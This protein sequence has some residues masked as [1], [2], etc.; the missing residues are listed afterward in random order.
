MEGTIIVGEPEI[1]A[2]YDPPNPLLPGPPGDLIRIEPIGARS[3]IRAWR[4][5]YHSTTRA[6]ED[7]MVSGMIAAP[8]RDPP[9]GGFPL[10]AS[11]H[12]TTGI[13]RRCAPSIDPDVP[14]PNGVSYF[15][16]LAPYVDAG[17][18]IAA[19]D[20][21]GLGAPGDPAYLVGE[22]ES[23]NVL[24][25]ARAARAL[26]DLRT[27]DPLLI[28]GHSQGGHAAAFAG[29]IIPQ[30]APEQRVAGVV[31]LAPAAELELMAAG[32]AMVRQPIP[33]VAFLVAAMYSWSLIYADA[34]LDA[35]LTEAGLDAV[36]TLKHH[37]G[38]DMYPPFMSEPPHHYF[39]P[40][41]IVLHQTWRSLIARNVPGHAKVDAPIFVGQGGAD[42]LVPPIMTELFV[43]RLQMRGDDVR[44]HHYPDADHNGVLDASQADVI[45]WL[46][47]QFRASRAR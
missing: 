1:P 10:I 39:N 5:L 46:G 24:D 12:G 27:A 26:P 14:V 11:A 16:I 7:I 8:D 40:L 31:L 23:R 36:E 42:Q 43:K 25:A 15:D 19:A 32:I 34:P 2:F 13:N 20:Y 44:L 6:G 21:Q 18:A 4:M 33:G 41:G 47:A 35:V 17:Y 38:L 30:Y 22:V 3:G 28:F 9:S 29:Q 45:D 37:C